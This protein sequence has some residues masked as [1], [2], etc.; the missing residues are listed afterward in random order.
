MTDAPH[1]QRARD[2]HAHD[3]HAHEHDHDVHHHAHPVGFI[4]FVRSIVVPHRHD[5]ADSVDQ[6]LEA[7]AQ[8][9]RA[10]KISLGVLG[11]TALL[12]ALVVAL[13]GSVAL[14]GDT[15]HNFSDAF[16]ALPLWVAFSLGR[17]P[18]NRRF[19]YGYGRAED[20]AGIFV[21]LL[22]ALSGA[23]TAWQSIER[24][25]H[26]QNVQH[27]AAV[28]AAAVV[29]V[30]G[31]EIVAQY[32]LR[33]GR[34][35]GSAALE[36]D[37]L[38]ARTDGVASLAVLVG[39]IG[40]ALGAEWADPVVGLM[41]SVVIFLVLLRTASSIGQRL[42]DAVDPAL[43]SQAEQ[44]VEHV[45]GVVDVG[46]VRIRWMGHRLHAEIRLV[47]DHRLSVVAAHDIAERAYHELLH[48]LPRLSDAIV[49]TDP[50]AQD[51]SDPHA[52]T[53]HHRARAEA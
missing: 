1:G 10:V 7:S 39:A 38:H 9:V 17:R 21:V 20:L 12:Q 8:G 28:M 11:L 41:I 51:G 35:I 50:S 32:R 14:L 18:P 37:G 36:A 5:T 23:L 42:M 13:S 43:V 52:E 30:A 16:T 40:V 31:N 45:D 19:N 53:R 49:H 25:L 2:E 22:V 46:D 24:L 3:H 15:L 4:G 34:R 44:I 33:V 6:A 26:P 48:Q 47:V 29:G 27:V